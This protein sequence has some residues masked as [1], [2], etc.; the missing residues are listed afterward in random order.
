M[1]FRLWGCFYLLLEAWTSVFYLLD[2]VKAKTMSA[3]NMQGSK[4]SRKQFLTKGCNLMRRSYKLAGPTNT[5]S[6]RSNFIVGI[7]VKKKN[8]F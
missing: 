7:K 1:T 6:G 3:D 2:A 5:N 4:C 8:R